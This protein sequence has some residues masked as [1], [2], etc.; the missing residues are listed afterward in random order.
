MEK[1]KKED[2]VLKGEDR[3]EDRVLKGEDALQTF[4]GEDR[5]TRFVKI[6][7]GHL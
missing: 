7:R 1:L 5:K 2:R 6:L 3:A 4:K